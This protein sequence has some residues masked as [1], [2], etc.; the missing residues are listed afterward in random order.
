MKNSLVRIKKT[1]QQVLPL[2]S[3]DGEHTLC[4]FP[5]D[6]ITNKGKR[7]HVQSVRTANIVDERQ[8]LSS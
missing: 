8:D 6:R 7:A 3:A 2:G 4:L 1:G 5:F